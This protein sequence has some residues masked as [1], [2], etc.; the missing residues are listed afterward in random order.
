MT[1]SDGLIEA[2]RRLVGAPEGGRVHSAVI[3]AGAEESLAILVDYGIGGI[4]KWVAPLSQIPIPE[5]PAVEPERVEPSQ[6]PPAMEE[7][8]ESPQPET[9]PATERKR[10][11]K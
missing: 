11:R 1:V 7:I 10:R 2:V 3:R 9:K 4:K 8:A 5:P 6:A